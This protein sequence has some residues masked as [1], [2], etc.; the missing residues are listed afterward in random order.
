MGVDK[1]CKS[2]KVRETQSHRTVF[3]SMVRSCPHKMSPIWLSK[4]EMKQADTNGH[5][6][7]YGEKPMKTNS[8]TKE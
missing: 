8:H 6:R 4:H 7:V 1:D 5:D 2:Q 3:P